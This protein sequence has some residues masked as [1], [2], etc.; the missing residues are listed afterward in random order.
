MLIESTSLVY[1][2]NSVLEHRAYVARVILIGQ[3]K[4]LIYKSIILA[5]RY[6]KIIRPLKITYKGNLELLIRNLE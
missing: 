4:L 1:I 3:R 5:T 6:L 2:G